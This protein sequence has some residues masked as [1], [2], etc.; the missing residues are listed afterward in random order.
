MAFGMGLVCLEIGRKW[1][2]NIFLF[3]LKKR[4]SLIK[5]VFFIWMIFHQAFHR[6]SCSP[7]DKFLLT[8]CLPVVSP[9]TTLVKCFSQTYTALYSILLEWRLHVHSHVKQNFPH[10]F[11]WSAKSLF[12]TIRR[13]GCRQ[14]QQC[15]G[16]GKVKKLFWF[17]KVRHCKRDLQQLVK[18]DLP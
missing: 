10:D 4:L 12:K 17:S 16:R 9:V 3:K 13:H 6:I 7:K 8:F 1:F 15:F 18:V 2:Q 11:F 5:A 14:Q